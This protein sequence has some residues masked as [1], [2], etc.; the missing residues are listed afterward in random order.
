[1]TEPAFPVSDHCD[2]SLFHNP[3]VGPAPQRPSAGRGLLPILRWRLGGTRAL[4]PSGIVDPPPPGDPRGA[5]PA[6]SFACL[7]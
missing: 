5:M 2:G 3:A 7:G 1:M 4:W 6:S